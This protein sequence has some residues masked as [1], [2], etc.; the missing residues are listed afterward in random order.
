M[1]SGMLFCYSR[2]DIED[3]VPVHAKW[4][5]TTF[6]TLPRTNLFNH[7]QPYMVVSL[8]TFVTGRELS[9]KMVCSVRPPHTGFLRIPRKTIE[10]NGGI[11]GVPEEAI[12]HKGVNNHQI[13]LV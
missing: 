10:I 5:G 6:Q 4:S 2:F 7:P 3:R 11:A 12:W 1:V 9:R 13:L 8:I